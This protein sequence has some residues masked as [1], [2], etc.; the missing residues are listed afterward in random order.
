MPTEPA[1]AGVGVH[2]ADSSCRVVQWAAESLYDRGRYADAAEAY[3][4]YVEQ[5]PE[6]VWAH[7]MLGLSAWKAGKPKTAER[8]LRAALQLDPDRLRVRVNL[9]RVLLDQDRP[10]EALAAFETVIARFG[11]STEPALLQEV[12]RAKVNK[13]KVHAELGDRQAASDQA[14]AGDHQSGPDPASPDRSSH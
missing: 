2:E 10:K 4:A 11:Q 14:P 13:G 1:T 8:A 5:R 9:A 12:A 7:Y 6:H 3:A